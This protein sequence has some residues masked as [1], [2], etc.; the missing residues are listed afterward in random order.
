[1]IPSPTTGWTQTSHL[2][3]KQFVCGFCD[4]KVG[5]TEG[6]AT[7]AVHGHDVAHVYICPNCR[8]P[9]YSIAGQ[10]FP[11][12]APSSAVEHLPAN[13]SAIYEEAR[14][15]AG[16]GAPTAAVLACRKILMNIAVHKGAAE[17]KRFIYYVKYLA[18]KGYVPPDGHDWVDHIRNK[19]NEATHEIAVMSANDAKELLEFTQMLLRLVY[20]FPNR[21]PKKTIPASPP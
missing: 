15:A 3:P 9:T 7:P 11:V 1:M 10:H 16:A 20:E 17:R 14:A 6:F 21:V 13:I 18:D 19:G 5:A 2:P 8:R 4:H 12:A